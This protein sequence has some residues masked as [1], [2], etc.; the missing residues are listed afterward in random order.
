V[1]RVN[2]H[3]VENAP[4]GS[5]QGLKVLEQKFGTTLNIFGAMAH[6][7]AA[8]EGYLGLAAAIEQHSSLDARTRA[9]I[10][11]TV[12]NV[13]ECGYC[14]GAY[15]LTAKAAGFDD[16][17]AKQIRRGAVD[18]EEALNALLGVARAVA[19]HKGHVDDGAWDAARRA[20]WAEQELLECFAETLR[21]TYTNYFNHFVRTE[22]DVPAAP[23]LSR[24][25]GAA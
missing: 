4:E 9:A 22:Q 5:R 13:N 2:M 7:P 12:S 15:T 21:A 14:E 18:G 19:A 11:L 6:A 20:G 3:D 17:Q 10:R 24:P 16:E 8:L 25:H 1:T 23:S